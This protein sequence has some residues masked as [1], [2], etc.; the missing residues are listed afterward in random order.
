MK[1]LT[2][3]FMLLCSNIENEQFIELSKLFTKSWE[4]MEK[5]YWGERLK[6]PTFK[7]VKLARNVKLTS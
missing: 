1:I 3:A 7:Q 4:E 5:C 2:V 6:L